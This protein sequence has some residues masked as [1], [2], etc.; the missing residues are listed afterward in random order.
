M[1]VNVPTG[2]AAA[3]SLVLLLAP[4]CIT[5][6]QYD[7]QRNATKHWE[8]IARN[9]EANQHQIES[10]NRSLKGRISELELAATGASGFREA[11]A[12][13]EEYEKRLKELEARLTGLPGV[14]KGDIEYLT[15]PEGPVLRIK[16]SVLFDSGS[17][18]VK[19]S[20]AAILKRIAEEIGSKSPKGIRVEGHTDND[21]VKRTIARYPLGNLQLSVQR[22]LRVADA[23]IKGGAVAAEKVSVAGFGEHRPI[24]DNASADGKRSNRRVELVLVER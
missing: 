17:E 6:E 22:A 24:A 8:E 1:P 16:D 2:A 19:A 21:P 9:M 15:G 12:L 20:A 23:L 14:E 4:G 13:R 3:L 11:S 7:K 10:E 18:E 5:R